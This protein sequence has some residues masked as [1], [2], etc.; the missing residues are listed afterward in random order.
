MAA[1][2]RSVW[3]LRVGTGL[4]RRELVVVSVRPNPAIPPLRA[5]CLKAVIPEP[6]QVQETRTLTG[7]KV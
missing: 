3:R 4:S 6:L 1:S 5:N 2:E 7:R